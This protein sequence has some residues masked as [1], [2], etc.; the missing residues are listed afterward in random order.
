MTIYEYEQKYG[1]LEWL[2]KRFLEKI[3]LPIFGEASLDIITPEVSI[4]RNDGSNRNWRIDFV[5]DT[6]KNKYA[7]ECDGFTY[8]ASNITKERFDELENKSNEINRQG[9]IPIRLS[10]QQIVDDPTIGIREIK[11][12]FRVH[13]DVKA[14]YIKKATAVAIFTAIVVVLLIFYQLNA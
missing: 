11:K 10:K 7:I 14:L 5:V 2:E 9:Y 3:Y 6:G 13:G 1:Q 12:T 4:P 8:H